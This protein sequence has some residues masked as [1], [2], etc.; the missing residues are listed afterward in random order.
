MKAIVIRQFGAPEV[1][2]VEDV[3]EPKAAAGEIV[4]KVHSV[5]VN[6]TLDCTVRAGKYPVTIQMPHV[7][8]VDPAGAVVEVGSGVTEFK[9]GDRVAVI[10]IIPCL[11]CKQCVKGLEANCVQSQHVGLH[12]W[13][14]YAE[15]VAVPQRN[16]FKL[17]DN[18]TFAEGTVITRHFP[19]AFNLL[20]SKTTVHAGETVLVMGASGA[21]GSCCVQV[22]KMFGA[23]VIAAA[24]A[25][26]RVE[27]GKSY[28]ADCGINYRSQNLADEV[29]QLTDGN[30]V[31]IVCENIS[32][33][34]LWPGAFDSLAIGGRMVT[35]GAHGGGTVTLDAKRLYLRRISILGAAGTNPPDVVKALDAAGKGKIR[36][37]INRR[38]PLHEVA[39]A[40]HIVENNRIAGKIILEPGKG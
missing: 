17:P 21:L 33:P 23:K 1:M 3:A 22:A 5:S 32:D 37:I 38:M 6:R 31:D 14:G 25:D 36:A 16:A 9:A 39:R 13:G 29:M 30:G 10:S 2:R 20:T 11:S 40:H 15:Y 4:I 12:R 26:E 18:L 8:G 24:G 28:G 19:M 35:A 27:L 34:T 7:L